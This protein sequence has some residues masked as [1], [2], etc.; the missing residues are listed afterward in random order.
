MTTEN[1]DTHWI[2]VVD[3]EGFYPAKRLGPY[4]TAGLAE[5][6]R[7]GAMR[8]LNVRRYTVAVV[9]QRDVGHGKQGVELV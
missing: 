4:A 9:S 6:A 3:G 1:D 8:L 5:R 2:E 7:R